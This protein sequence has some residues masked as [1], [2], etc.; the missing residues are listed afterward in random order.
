MG[1]QSSAYRLAGADGSS[2]LEEGRQLPPTGQ[3]ERYRCVDWHHGGAEP[4]NLPKK[5]ISVR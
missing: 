4:Q 2:R 1:L 3:Q 5:K